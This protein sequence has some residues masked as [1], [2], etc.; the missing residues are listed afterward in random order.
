M[1]Y[2][3]S[4]DPEVHVAQFETM[5]TLHQYTEG[6]KC[7]IFSTTLTGMAKQ[8]FRAL[9]PDSIH[10]FEQLHDTFMCQFASSKRAEKTVMSLMDLKQEP[11]GTLKEFAARFTKASLEVPK[12]ESQIKGY[13]FVRGLRLGA[14]F[15]NLQVKQPRDFDDI[16]ARLPGYIQLEEA[17]DAQKTEYGGGKP[18][19]VENKIEASETRPQG[20]AP[21]R[22]MP[23]RVLPGKV[24]LAYQPPR[25]EQTY[26]GVNNINRLIDQ[27]P[28]N[29]PQEEIFHLIKNEPWFRA[30]S[31]FAAGAPKPGLNG[32]LY[33]YH[34]HY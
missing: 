23:P 3:G 29:K 21:Y 18:K 28:L 32:L 10:S 14:F 11:T 13:A 25:N 15:D 6:I 34:N 12:A 20:R 27:T 7:R 2:D 8:W 1:E 33:Q 31:D 4:D 17:R 16:L 22:G 19:E 9:G 5:I 26:I 30:P 24:Q